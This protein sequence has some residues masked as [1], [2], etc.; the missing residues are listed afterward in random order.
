MCDSN[1]V[2]GRQG[3]N[4]PKNVQRSPLNNNTFVRVFWSGKSKL[5]LEVENIREEQSNQAIITTRI[6]TKVPA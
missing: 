6:C 3:T 2:K 1:R 4:G 5:P